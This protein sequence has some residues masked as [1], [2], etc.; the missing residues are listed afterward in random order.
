MSLIKTKQ[1]IKHGVEGYLLVLACGDSFLAMITFCLK[2][3]NPV[4][5]I[6]KLQNG[7]KHLDNAVL[8]VI[9]HSYIF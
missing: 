2:K 6:K 9:L 4:F 8:F 5:N 1:N 3:N 7:T